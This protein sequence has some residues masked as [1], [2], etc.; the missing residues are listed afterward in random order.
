MTRTTTKRATKQQQVTITMTTTT[1]TTRCDGMTTST[2]RCDDMTTTTTTKYIQQTKNNT[3]QIPFEINFR[4]S[5]KMISPHLA[6]RWLSLEAILDMFALADCIVVQ[7]EHA[8][9]DLIGHVFVIK[10]TTILQHAVTFLPRLV[11]ITLFP[12][13]PVTIWFSD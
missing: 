11:G 8:Y 9:R 10:H 12:Q 2:T 5:V 4:V 13:K 1:T 7:F 3:T 6:H